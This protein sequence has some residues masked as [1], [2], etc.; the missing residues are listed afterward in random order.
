VLDSGDHAAGGPTGGWRP[1][2]SD[3]RSIGETTT[4]YCSDIGEPPPGITFAW[5]P[6]HADTPAVYAHFGLDRVLVP[7]RDEY[8]SRRVV[9]AY[10]GQPNGTVDGELRRWITTPAHR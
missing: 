8:Q 7:A 4:S 9:E 5:R 6:A 1:A 10:G 3:R 2:A